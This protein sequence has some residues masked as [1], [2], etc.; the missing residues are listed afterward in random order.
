MEATGIAIS[1]SPVIAG[2]RVVYPNGGICRVKGVETK[3]IAGQT[4]TMLML[5][6]EEDGATVMVPQN[7]VD[8]IGLRK[9]ATKE[10]IDVLFE[11]LTH[12][13][14]D[15]ELDWKIRHK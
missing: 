2:E 12:S 14:T 9:V 11:F 15:P 5:Q 1:G 13:S 10:A 3:S 4:W 6:R 7:K 8:A